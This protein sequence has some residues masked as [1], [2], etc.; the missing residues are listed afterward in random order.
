MGPLAKGVDG[1]ILRLKTFA[2][3]RTGAKPSWTL[4]GE[5]I[6]THVLRG[7]TAPSALRA[8]ILDALAVR[9]PIRKTAWRAYGPKTHQA[10]VH[11]V[12][13]ALFSVDEARQTRIRRLPAHAAA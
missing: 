5:G 6:D 9:G 2:S 7:I 8:D 10:T 3:M 1:N 11:A 4:G 12:A 13:L